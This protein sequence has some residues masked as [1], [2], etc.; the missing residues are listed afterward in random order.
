MSTLISI[1]S[2]EHLRLAKQG[3]QTYCRIQVLMSVRFR[4]SREARDVCRFV[5]SPVSQPHTQW[6]LLAES[7]RL[8]RPHG[9]ESGSASAFLADASRERQAKPLQRA[10][11]ESTG[12]VHRSLGGVGWVAWCAVDLGWRGCG[13]LLT[14]H[15]LVDAC[16]AT[17]RRIRSFT[18]L[19]SS[20][21][22]Y[23]A[24]SHGGPSLQALGTSGG[25]G[26]ALIFETSAFGQKESTRADPK[27]A[28]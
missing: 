28:S 17:L 7:S 20:C 1:R 26:E 12:P 16:A 11:P 3:R 21:A 22:R 27:R 8:H 15:A 14:L 4:V 24:V 2:T 10:D 25:S 18:C 5:Q 9:A 6:L 13:P 19:D 23:M